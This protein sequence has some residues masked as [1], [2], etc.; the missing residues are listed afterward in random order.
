VQVHY[1]FASKGEALMSRWG[2]AMFRLIVCA[3]ERTAVDEK[4][5]R[6]LNYHVVVSAVADTGATVNQ[7]KGIIGGYKSII[8]F[9]T[10][11]TVLDSYNI[12]EQRDVISLP[13]KLDDEEKRTLVFRV[14]EQHWSHDAKYF[15]FT[16]NCADES[17]KLLVQSLHN[18]DRLPVW[19]PMQLYKKLA[20]LGIIDTSLISDEKVAIKK[21][22]LFKAR[23]DVLK[24]NMGLLKDLDQENPD[25]YADINSYRNKTTPE[26][27]I[28]LFDKLLKTVASENKIKTIATF[29]VLEE[30]IYKLLMMEMNAKYQEKLVPLLSKYNNATSITDRFSYGIPSEDEVI[31]RNHDL[32]EIFKTDKELNSLVQMMQAEYAEELR[33]IRKNHEQFKQALSQE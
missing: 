23:N 5:L 7:V 11:Q 14:L 15:F 13:L 1:F 25:F 17:A 26:T 9:N 12:I 8:T 21:G 10:M 2:H 20:K 33:S 6:D 22:Y 18:I 28:Q 16:N 24:K 31:I 4:C 27:R 3:P 19:Q 29:M 32:A 30:N